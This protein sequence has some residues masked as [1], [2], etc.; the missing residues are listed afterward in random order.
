LPTPT[1]TL[2]PGA[3]QTLTLNVDA[4]T[5]AL[6]GDLSLIAIATAQS[7]E[8][9]RDSDT[10]LLGISPSRG[11]EVVFD[12][13]SQTLPAPGPATFLLQV[14][15][16]GN[17]EE[18][19]QAV[20]T[21]AS[22]PVSAALEG[23]DGQPTQRIETFR[24]PALATGLLTLDTTLQQAGTGQVTITVTALDAPVLTGADTATVTTQDQPPPPPPPPAPGDPAAIPTLNE[25]MQ[26]LM[27]LLMLLALMWVTR[28]RRYL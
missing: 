6:P 18:A 13:D 28:Q 2:A 4:I 3:S 19:Y 20:I 25:W 26:I 10:T 21:T 5:T 16:T 7:N 1:V 17:R 27:A 8:S 24:L 23:L 14:Q 12:P 15:N 22:G 9:V 11:L